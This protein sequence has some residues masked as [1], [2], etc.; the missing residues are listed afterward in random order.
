M[1]ASTLPAKSET[2]LLMARQP[3]LFLIQI[4]ATRIVSG[5]GIIKSDTTIIDPMTLNSGR[6]I[7]RKDVY[8]TIAGST[9]YLNPSGPLFDGRWKNDD[10]N[11]GLSE[12]EAFALVYMHET[13]H[14]T[15]DF[16]PDGYSEAQSR[17]NSVL[18]RTF[19]FSDHPRR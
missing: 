10:F 2:D 4:S 14:R 9:I 18:I 5:G 7:D 12:A 17:L 8:A 1:S 19:C 3:H 16:P 15:G 11:Q 13:A 6:L